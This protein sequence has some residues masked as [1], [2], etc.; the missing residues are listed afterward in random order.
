M[1]IV[2]KEIKPMLCKYLM[3]I[4]GQYVISFDSRALIRKIK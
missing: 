3:K 2:V 1:F 4:R